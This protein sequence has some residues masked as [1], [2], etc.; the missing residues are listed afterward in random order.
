MASI[1]IAP[2]KKELSWSGCLVVGRKV[3]AEG[4][5]QWVHSRLPQRVLARRHAS[6]VKPESI[7]HIC[8]LEPGRKRLADA[9]L[10]ADIGPKH[11][12]AYEPSVRVVPVEAA[13]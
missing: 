9:S 12:C 1:E 5:Y 3:L 13:Q 7:A 4:T 8:W 10:A 2:F 11:S 6:G